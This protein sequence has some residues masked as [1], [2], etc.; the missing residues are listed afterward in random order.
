MSSNNLRALRS[1]LTTATRTVFPATVSSAS[2]TV[3]LARNTSNLILPAFF[4]SNSAAAKRKAE[5]EAK[6]KA[7]AE[8]EAKRKA[9]AEAEAKRK[10][11]AEA[12][13]KRKAEADAEA[14]R[15][16]DA[17]RIRKEK[18]A[19]AR[20]IDAEAEVERR[21]KIK[22]LDDAFAAYEK[23]YNKRLDEA[24]KPGSRMDPISL[25]QEYLL[26]RRAYQKARK[27]L[28]NGK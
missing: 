12:A 6:R 3:L 15:K 24:L 13:A 25:Q 4:G 8:A 28:E 18:E 16:A 27:K 9:E 22:K 20:E 17:E 23:D 2:L 21:T 1:P 11:D 14:K 5:A 26:K 19:L 10:A 7:E